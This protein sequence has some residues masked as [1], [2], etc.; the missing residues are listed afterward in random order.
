MLKPGGGGTTRLFF[1]IIRSEG[2]ARAA[3]A[4]EARVSAVVKNIVVGLDCLEE[5]K[6]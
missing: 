3:R 1:S 4:R 5:K 6:S 2:A